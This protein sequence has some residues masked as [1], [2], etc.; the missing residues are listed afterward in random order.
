MAEEPIAGQAKVMIAFNAAPLMQVALAPLKDK[1]TKERLREFGGF[2][3]TNL[4]MATGF[5][6]HKFGGKKGDAT[7][8]KTQLERVVED[9]MRKLRGRNRPIAYQGKSCSDGQ[10]VHRRAPGQSQP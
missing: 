4:R 5:L 3:T 9:N 1:I 7:G 8:P 10:Q 6:L 2:Q